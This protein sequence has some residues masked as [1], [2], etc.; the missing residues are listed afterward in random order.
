MFQAVDTALMSEVLP[1]AKSFAKDLGV[2]NIAATLPQTLAPARRRAI[3]LELAAT[4]AVPRRHR[5][6]HPRRLRRLADQG[7]EVIG[8]AT[9]LT[10]GTTS[11]FAAAGGGAH[12]RAVVRRGPAG[13]LVTGLIG[14]V[15]FALFGLAV[16]QDVEAPF[17]QP[18]DDAWRRL[19][20]ASGLYDELGGADGLPVPRRAARRRAD[21]PADP[22]GLS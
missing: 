12:G 15:L 17:T 22:R 8:D 18:L 13:L 21:D 3:V 9:V 20:G 2:V 4:R 16:L 10:A 1:S 5:A 19:V 14:L 7:G 11:T 6:Q